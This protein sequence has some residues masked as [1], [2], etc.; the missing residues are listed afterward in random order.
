M[1]DNSQ[2]REQSPLGPPVCQSS[3]HIIYPP[4]MNHVVTAVLLLRLTDKDPNVAK[5]KKTTNNKNKVVTTGSPIIPQTS[6]I[7]EK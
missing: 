7:S 1:T 4:N 6:Q 2:L 3:S 5:G